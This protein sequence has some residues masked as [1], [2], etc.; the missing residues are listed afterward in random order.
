MSATDWKEANWEEKDYV[1]Y[2]TDTG[3]TTLLQV[4]AVDP[5]TREIQFIHAT[6]AGSSTLTAGAA[7]G[8][9]FYM[10]GSRNNDP[11][12]LYGI[13]RLTDAE[14]VASGTLYGITVQRRWKMHTI[15]AAG[16]AIG[17]PL[18][19][20]MVLRIEKR[21]GKNPNMIAASY[22][23]YEKFL[24]LYE[25]HKRFLVEPR[26]IK[27][28]KLKIKASYNAIAFAGTKGDIPVIPERFVEDDSMYFLN[29]DYIRVYRRP[30]FGWF[31]D[32]GTVFL[33]EADDDAYEARYGGYYQNFIVPT[34]HGL[35]YGLST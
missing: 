7:A 5:D 25:D 33:R 29:M 10:Q 32:D 31:D 28:K 21:V 20:K 1:H 13:A 27:N 18:M 23:Q 12:G 6:D 16:A 35:I 2:N 22:T 9:K 15:N 14:Y 19:N 17:T 4:Y 3:K 11:K 8:N 34:F 24:N 26:Y 30:K